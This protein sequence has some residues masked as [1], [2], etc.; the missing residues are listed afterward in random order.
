M[1]V[2][3]AYERTGSAAHK[4][5]VNN[6]LNAW[7]QNTPPPWSWDGWNDDIGWFT[8]ALIRGYQITGNTNFLNQAKYGFD[9]AYGRGWDT[10]YN[11]G[12]I[13][14]QQPDK[15]PAG[16]KIQKTALANNSLGKVAC[17]LYQAT[18]DRWYLDR[19]T[20]IYSWVWNRLYDPS[21]GRVYTAID[22]NNVVDSGMAVYNH[23][24]FADYANLLYEI[25]GNVTYYND[26]KRTIDFVR[27]NMTWSGVLADS[28]PNKDTWADE[29]ARAVGHFARDHRQWGTY[30]GWMVQNADAILRNRRGDYGITW[31]Q[32]DQPT[33]TTDNGRW[34]TQY[35]SAVSWLQFTPV[36][37][38]N[39]I[40]G[41]HTLV[42]Q[43]TGLAIDNAGLF[44]NGQGVVQWGPSPNNQNQKWLITSNSDGTYNLVSMSS[45]QALDS[46]GGSTQNNVQL[47]Q[48]QT[49]RDTNQ[50]WWIEAQSDGSYRIRNAA[51][52]LDLD[53][54]SATTNGAP[55]IQWGWSGGSQ[56]KW[57]LR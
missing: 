11:G 50:R 20:Q 27:N 14:E 9:Y 3:D 40:A 2:E 5:L 13:W 29:F 55:L 4:A 8:L 30:H 52:G 49:T 45:W 19:A 25:T 43:K 48:W 34:S 36:T 54:A 23:G 6:L 38:P 44:G 7:L 10:Q 16:D 22:R 47:V 46:P 1:A 31:N 21:T 33:S 15:T 18:H 41:V 42:N 51:S 35:A 17:Y 56:Q 28:D 37:V 26:A 57:I 53:G 32:W 12:G 24:T 39:S